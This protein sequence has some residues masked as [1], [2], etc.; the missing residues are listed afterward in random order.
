MYV[1]V[2]RRVWCIIIVCLCMCARQCA[3]VRNNN[4]IN[5]PF[6]HGQSG[7]CS[8]LIGSGCPGDSIMFSNS[9]SLLE[10]PDVD[11]ALTSHE[12]LVVRHG[13]VCHLCCTTT[14]KANTHKQDGSDINKQ[15]TCLKSTRHTHNVVRA[16]QLPPLPCSIL[17]SRFVVS[18]KKKNK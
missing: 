13:Q 9:P 16:G 1:H 17:F 2:H 14:N 3:H 12:H 8:W 7:R 5:L 15:K 4:G 10:V 11:T 6:L 18:R